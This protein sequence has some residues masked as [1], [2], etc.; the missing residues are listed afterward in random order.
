MSLSRRIAMLFRAK[1]NKALDRAE[2]DIPSSGSL[3]RLRKRLGGAGV[4]EV[5]RGTAVHL[6]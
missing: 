3:T 5:K 4:E 2:A 6:D 1:V